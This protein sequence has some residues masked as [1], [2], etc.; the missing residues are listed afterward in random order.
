[1]NS[2]DMNSGDMNSG[3]MNSGHMNSGDWN[4]GSWNSGDMNSGDMNSGD[5][6]SGSW[7]SGD[8]NSGFFNTT[9]PKVRLFNID[10]DLNYDEIEIPFIDLQINEW[11]PE[12]KMT[13]SQKIED[14]YFY[15]KK[16]TLITRSY[17]EAWA[18]AWPLLSELD[19][20]KFIDLPN[21]NSDIFFEITGIKL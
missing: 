1:M 3:D 8:R 13:E 7:N 16:G 6:N 20:N 9:T 4:S 5:R 15:V 2:G 14:K 19:K 12:E 21:F 11:I 10:T 18:L 17:K